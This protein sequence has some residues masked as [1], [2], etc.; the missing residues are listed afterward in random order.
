MNHKKSALS[1]DVTAW[2]LRRTGLAGVKRV[3][4]LS[5]AVASDVGT[6]RVENQDRAVIARGIDK[7]GRHF[8]VA[9]LADGIGGMNN[10]AESA[11]IA[12]GTFITSV[13]QQARSGSNH[14]HD[15]LQAAVVAANASVVSTFGGK[16]GTT[17]VAIVVRPGRPACWL[18]VGDSR[19][20]RATG[21]ELTQISV[22]DTIAG[23]L[24][25]NAIAG[26]E[27][28]MLLQ[29][30]GMTD[31]LVPHI[32]EFDLAGVN[33]LLLTSD[34]VHFLASTPGL[35]GQIVK[36]AADAAVCVKR[37]S[38]LSKWFGGAD[39]A[40]VAMIELSSSWPLIDALPRAPFLDVW[41]AF[42]EFRVATDTEVSKLVPAQFNKQLPAPQE[43]QEHLLDL[44]FLEIPPLGSKRFDNDR[45]NP[46]A[47]NS[48]LAKK[49]NAKPAAPTRAKAK[50]KTSG[51]TAPFYLTESNIYKK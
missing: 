21:R 39:N 3:E 45:M 23:Q 35:M 8:I 12:I 6:V 9:A 10:G 30:I 15:W 19:V 24:G 40:S 49:R 17:L 18:S 48:Q 43:K 16:G 51:S 42:G 1:N 7:T 32:G 27:Q 33:A 38:D 25:K 4:L 2:L 29:F 14:S 46:N 31:A 11:A 41:D 22:D 36:N 37:L 26:S 34:G 13:S 20:Y 5:A 50:V 44:Q 28:S 47:V